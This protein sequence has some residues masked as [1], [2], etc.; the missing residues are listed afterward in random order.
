MIDTLNIQCFKKN[1]R[2]MLRE[3]IDLD[4]L[5]DIIKTNVE[6]KGTI[7]NFK[8]HKEQEWVAYIN[9]KQEL[10]QKNIELEAE[11]EEEKRNFELQVESEKKEKVIKDRL[12]RLK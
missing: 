10:L 2:T 12:N 6:R 4:E 9:K 8:E 5:F 7:V 1:M 11:K 3:P